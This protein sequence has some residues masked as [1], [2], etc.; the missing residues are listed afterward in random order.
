MKQMNE[1][2]FFCRRDNLTIRGREFLP[3][4]STLPAIII[5]HG[6]G[7]N[8]KNLTNYCET[9][10]S[11]G[12]AAYCFD[13]CGGCAYDEG[14]SDGSST[15]MTILT[16][17][18]DLKAVID[19]VKTL[20]YIDATKLILM[21]FSQGGFVSALT[22]AQRANEIDKLILMCPA[23]CIPDDARNGALAKTSYDINNVPEI[24]DCGRMLL[25]RQFHETVVHM[26]PFQE[27][28]PY[29]GPVLL[30]HGTADQTVNYRYAIQAKNSYLPDQCHLQLIK[31]AGHSLNDKQTA[32]AIASVQQFLLE[33]KEI[34]TINVTTTGRELKK[35]EGSYRKTAVLFTGNSESPYFTGTILPGAEDVQEHFENQLVSVRADYTLNG[36]DYTGQKCQI[37]IVNQ[38][39]NEEWKP[40]IET[41]SKALNFLNHSDLTA[42]LEGYPGGLT[43][44]IFSIV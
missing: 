1:R 4:G 34:L 17:C 38:N 41:D 10:A 32:S 23:L 36:F 6:F 18:D 16:E 44:R 2:E 22:A 40:V 24:I 5:S 42:V 31:D 13:F 30:I 9:L 14:K 21:G 19:Y 43:V 28:T 39:V 33:K 37:H 3:K 7:G 8:S 26:N 25:S 20:S 12:Y 29:K 35:E 15:N 11:W 27:I